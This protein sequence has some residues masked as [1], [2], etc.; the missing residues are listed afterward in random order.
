MSVCSRRKRNGLGIP[1]VNIQDRGY[2]SCRTQV[3]LMN[4][5]AAPNLL[6]NIFLLHAFL[7]LQIYYLRCSCCKEPS[8][9]SV[10]FTSVGFSLRCSHCCHV[11]TFLYTSHVP[12]SDTSVITINPRP[13]ESLCTDFILFC[14]VQKYRLNKVARVFRLYDQ[15]YVYNTS[16]H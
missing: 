5:L 16:Y 1:K 10:C 2:I 12:T 6:K 4:T 8:A 15:I 3:Y 11:Y 7:F 9:D 13:T 14:L